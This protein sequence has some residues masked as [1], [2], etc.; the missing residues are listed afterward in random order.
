MAVVGE[1]D[2]RQRHTVG[3]VGVAADRLSQ[4][5][6]HPVRGL[7]LCDEGIERPG[8]R[9]HDVAPRLVVGH[10]FDRRAA[11]HQERTHE[12]FGD[13]VAGVVVLAREILLADVAEDVVDARHHLIAGQGEGVGGIQHGETGHDLLV[14]EDMTYLLLGG[15]VGDDRAG[16]HLRARAH[17]GQHAADG[18]YLAGRLLETQIV[19]LP[20]ILVAVHGHGDRLGVVAHRSAAHGEQQIRFM[21]SSDRDALVHLVAGGIGHDARYL[22]DILARGAQTAHDLVVDA[23]LFDGPAAVDEH[24]IL[25][26]LLKF[27][28][29]GRYRPFPEKELCGIAI[30]E[31]TEHILL[32]AQGFPG[33]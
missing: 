3:G 2:R 10:I 17:H 26:V 18:D 13:I 30:S 33:A 27:G 7:A 11:G 14:R 20:G 5:M 22:P 23:V 16:V 4:H 19:L 28:S 24:D 29:E 25:P 15:G 9:P 1:R 12:P 21:R 8:S 6:H 32:L 31:I